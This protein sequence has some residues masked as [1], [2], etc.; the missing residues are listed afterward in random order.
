[1]V[2]HVRPEIKV[3][4]NGINKESFVKRQASK[5]WDLNRSLLGFTTDIIKNSTQTAYNGTKHVSLWCVLKLLNVSKYLEHVSYL[6]RYCSL[7]FKNTYL[8]NC[9]SKAAEMIFDLDQFSIARDHFSST[10][11]KAPNSHRI[12]I[13]ISLF[14]HAFYWKNCIWK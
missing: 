10:N 12:K 2:S 6:L 3:M 8:E 4:Q 14:Q 7:E 9:S 5:I 1:M 11:C 13:Q